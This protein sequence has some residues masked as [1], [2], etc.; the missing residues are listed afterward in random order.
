[1]KDTKKT[2][3]YISAAIFVVG[4]TL[5]MGGCSKESSMGPTIDEQQSNQIIS[6]AK[7]GAGNTG[8]KS[9]QEGQKNNGF[10][11]VSETFHFDFKQSIYKGG[12]VNKQHGATLHI[13][14][15][16]LKPPK[17]TPYGADVIITM[18]IK[19]EEDALLFEF[20]PSG[21][22][23]NPNAELWFDWSSLG[24]INA[25]LYYI[26]K[27][28]DY[29]EQEPECVDFKNKRMMIHIHHFSRYAIAAE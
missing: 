22:E 3:G 11:A 7:K 5:N 21:C 15:G 28:G 24:T 1:M 19:K 14:D 2:I 10:D 16:A 4:L 20:G 8:N 9:K 29:V 26:K 18:T 13:K 6:L 25:N 27:N 23:F 17:G 12:N